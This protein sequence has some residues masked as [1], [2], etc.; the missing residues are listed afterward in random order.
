MRIGQ[1]KL[2]LNS[3]VVFPIAPKCIFTRNITSLKERLKLKDCTGSGPK[4]TITVQL[5]SDGC[6]MPF[7]LLT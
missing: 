4:R 7:R 5:G 1:H 6:A 3:K 2:Y